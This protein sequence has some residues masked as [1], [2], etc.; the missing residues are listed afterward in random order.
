M[1]DEKIIPSD[2][3]AGVRIPQK[4]KTLPKIYTEADLLAVI[5]A[6]ET[7][8]RDNAIFSLFIDSGI[9]LKLSKLTLN[10]TAML[11]SPSKHNMR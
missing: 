7:N 1:F 5:K 6:A 10:V 11:L 9:R 8:L 3:I 2:P 4:P